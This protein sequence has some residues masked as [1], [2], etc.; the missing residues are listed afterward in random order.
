MMAVRHIGMGSYTKFIVTV[1][2]FDGNG[3][4]MTSS[5]ISKTLELDISTSSVTIISIKDSESNEICLKFQI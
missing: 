1:E 4:E 5:V 3:I 2:K